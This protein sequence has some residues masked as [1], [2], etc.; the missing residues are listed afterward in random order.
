MTNRIAISLLIDGVICF[1]CSFIFYVLSANSYSKIEDQISKWSAI[2]GFA[3]I[4]LALQVKLF[5]W[6]VSV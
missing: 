2:I 6:S 4:L 3:L 5:S 1:V